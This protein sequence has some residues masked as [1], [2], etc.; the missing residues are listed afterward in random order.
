MKDI[1]NI[2][3]LSYEK[4][5]L[6]IFEKIEGNYIVLNIEQINLAEE[7]K[8]LTGVKCFDLRIQNNKNQLYFESLIGR[9]KEKGLLLYRDELHPI[10]LNDYCFFFPFLDG[11]GL[12]VITNSP[13]LFCEVYNKWL[14]LCRPEIFHY[15]MIL[16]IYIEVLGMIEKE[17]FIT[18]EIAKKLSSARRANRIS[19]NSTRQ[20]LFELGDKFFKKITDISVYPRLKDHFNLQKKMQAL[21]SKSI[22]PF[23][24]NDFK[25]QAWLSFSLTVILYTFISGDEKL[26]NSVKSDDLYKLRTICEIIKG[27]RLS[28]KF[29]NMFF[30]FCEKYIKRYIKNH[31]YRLKILLKKSINSDVLLNFH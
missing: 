14:E 5:I 9:D 21:S 28:E 8:I 31:I 1:K 4:K 26:F 13:Q 7:Y 24:E 19:M 27:R 18:H 11:T 15:C 30:D 12:M 10:N 23:I 20:N 16:N 17:E 22:I 3:P 2:L 6:T 29:F 25:G